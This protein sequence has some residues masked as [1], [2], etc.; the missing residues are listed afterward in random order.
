FKDQIVMKTWRSKKGLCHGYSE[1]YNYVA[2]RVGLESIMIPGTSKSHPTHI[3][4]L[5]TVADH[6]WNA[7]KTNG[8]WHL[9]DVTWAAGGIDGATKKFVSKFNDSYFFTDPEV[10]L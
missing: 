10:F 2:K 8:K 1:L 3:G 5:P 6:A 7:V 4:K 9:I